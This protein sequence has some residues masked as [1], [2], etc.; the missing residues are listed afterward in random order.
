MLSSLLSR[1]PARIGLL[2]GLTLCLSSAAQAQLSQ[3]VISEAFGGGHQSTETPN[4]DYVEIY[5]RGPNAVS[6]NGLSVQV[7]TSTGAWQVIALNNV[8]LP[9]RQ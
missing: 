2:A 1:F 5:N 8:L 7:A 3:L 4:A 9:A 6:L